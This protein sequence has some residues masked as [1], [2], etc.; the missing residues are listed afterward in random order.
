VHD[1]DATIRL[2]AWYDREQRDLPWRDRAD[3][4][5]IWVSEVML[6]QTQV[7]RVRPIYE[8]FMDRFPTVHE[9]AA[10][11]ID[12]VLAAWSGLGYYRRARQL[13][14]ASIRIVEGGASVPSE[15]EDLLALPGIGRYTAAAIASIAFGR[16]VPAVDG[17]VERVICRWLALE[18]DP[19]RA[20]G[21]REVRSAA[22]AML[23]VD[24]PGDSNQALMELGALVCRPRRPRCET[25]PLA[26][27]CRAR[28]GGRAEEYPRRPA[29]AGRRERHRWA[30]AV[31]ERD[32]ALLLFRRP[33]DAEL[34]AGLWELPSIEVSSGQE[35]GLARA[36]AR[37]YGGRWSL[38]PIEATVRHTITFRDLEVGVLRARWVPDPGGGLPARHRW[39]PVAT[40]GQLATSTL[41]K[42][43]I[44]ALPA[45]GEA[46]G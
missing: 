14:A 23:D 11:S 5:A 8:R 28:A 42:K 30:A 31:V 27:D 35:A 40:V 34:L 29:S 4:Y 33:S 12:D 44:D 25:C 16:P 19:R 3:A 46:R 13:Q 21:G 7:E 20:A 38:D 39:E 6:Q 45:G 10:A 17:N 1:D 15:T 32:G 26:L 36:F 37:R 22:A 18:K 41:V 43:V 24:R 2:L 9:L